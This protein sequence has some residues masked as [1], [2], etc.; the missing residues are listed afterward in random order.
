[1]VLQELELLLLV[2]RCLLKWSHRE[3]QSSETGGFIFN[4]GFAQLHFKLPPR[5]VHMKTVFFSRSRIVIS[6]DQHVHPKRSVQIKNRIN[7]HGPLSLCAGG[8]TKR[9]KPCDDGISYFGISA[10]LAGC[11]R[12]ASGTGPWTL[13]CYGLGR[14]S[15][16]G[17][18]RPRLADRR[19][20]GN[21]RLSGH[22]R[23]GQEA[24]GGQQAANIRTRKQVRSIRRAASGQ[25]HA[26]ITRQSTGV[27]D[28][29]VKLKLSSPPPL[30][31]PAPLNYSTISCR[32]IV[33]EDP[34]MNPSSALH[35][36]S[37]A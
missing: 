26:G 7:N 14:R 12:Q 13:H 10:S 22:F 1:M 2:E 19:R 17:G 5:T 24:S 11:C 21:R 33:T 23:A 15:D 6:S 16:Y 9:N 32:A 34:K 37:P 29:S 25:F 36:S 4:A 27:R 31:P 8:K 20:G 28:S 30:V 18:S 3:S 35:D